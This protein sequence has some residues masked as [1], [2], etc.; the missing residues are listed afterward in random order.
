MTIQLIMHNT[1]THGSIVC[2]CYIICMGKRVHLND[3]LVDCE[4]MHL[5]IIITPYTHNCITTENRVEHV[6][7]GSDEARGTERNYN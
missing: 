3:V 4:K 5:R 7:R 2:H 1:I 6:G